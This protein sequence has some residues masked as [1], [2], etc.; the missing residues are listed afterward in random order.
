MRRT[1][2]QTPEFYLANGFLPGPKTKRIAVEMPNGASIW[3]M[4]DD[5]H[6]SSSIIA[7]SW[8]PD[9]TRFIT[10]I[11]G[12][13][14]IFLDIGSFV[15]WFALTAG[16]L[17]GPTGAVFAFEP[18]RAAHDLLRRSVLA[19]RFEAWV[20]TFPLAL[21]D[22]AGEVSLWR[23]AVPEGTAA[24]NL[25]HTWMDGSP[26]ATGAE[27]VGAAQCCRLDDLSLGRHV[28]V[29][30]L[31]VEGS[32]WRVLKGAERTIR[33]SHPVIICEL[34]P[35]QLERASGVR[36]ADLIALLEGWGYN[37]YRIEPSGGLTAWSPAD[38]PEGEH[39]YKTIVFR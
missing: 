12:P 2:I 21:S 11:L 20:S 7:G 18:Q 8:E 33:S 17:V 14:S 6:V 1:F 4:L 31:D 23:D 24:S 26:S 15:G 34:F 37:S 13:G 3:V 16:P 29:V 22:H 39:S 9:E 28:D 19:N 30:K 35:A 5:L 38:M 36:G 27:H 25:G 32:E 10:S